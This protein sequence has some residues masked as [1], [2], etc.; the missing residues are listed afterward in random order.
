M[1]F[2]ELSNSSRYGVLG[3]LFAQGLKWLSE[4]DLAS[5]EVGR[6]ELDGDRLFALVQEY[7]TKPAVD[8]VW[9]AHRRYADIQFLRSGIE[10]IGWQDISRMTE[11]VPYDTTRDA[12][13]FSGE[14]VP[15]I[16]RPGQLAIYFPQ[17]VHQPGVAVGSAAVASKIVIKVRIAD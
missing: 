14:G 8:A 11:T 13:F 6:I 16:I 2:A 7:T 17:D 1:I 12:A 9:E 15:M 4:T 10:S 3:P 5:L